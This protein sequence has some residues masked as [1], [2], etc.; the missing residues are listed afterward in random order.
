MRTLRSSFTA[1]LSCLDTRVSLC[2]LNEYRVLWTFFDA[3][4]CSC[5]LELFFSPSFSMLNETVAAV[6]LYLC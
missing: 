5:M 2:N 3:L 1:T 6:Y 4:C